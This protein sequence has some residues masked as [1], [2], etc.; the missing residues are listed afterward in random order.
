MIIHYNG[1]KRLPTQI[2][3]DLSSLMGGK[4]GTRPTGSYEVKRYISLTKPLYSP[5]PL[6]FLR[7]PS[8]DP[9][10]TL[11][12]NGIQATCG[13][14]SYTYDEELTPYIL[15]ISKTGEKLSS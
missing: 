5:I 13:D 6:D 3:F 11:K 8:D 14:C 4:A 9:S 2:A 12:V 15:S 1:L 10:L 7:I